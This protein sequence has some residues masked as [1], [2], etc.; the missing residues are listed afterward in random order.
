MK[1]V[2]E[3][4]RDLNLLKHLE[5]SIALVET[6]PD[7]DMREWTF[8]HLAL[9][10]W[11][12]SFDYTMMDWLSP[13]TLAE[14]IAICKEYQIYM[15]D[16]ARRKHEKMNAPLP[17]KRKSDLPV[18]GPRKKMKNSGPSA[19]INGDDTMDKLSFEIAKESSYKLSHLQQFKRLFALVSGIFQMRAVYNQQIRTDIQLRSLLLACY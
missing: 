16:A 12:N 14:I 13:L 8:T 17:N 11:G 19:S 3:H 4:R 1:A 7:G 9:S 2:R 18:Q 6:S 5:E 15:S 10:H